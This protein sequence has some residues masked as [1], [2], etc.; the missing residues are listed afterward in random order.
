MRTMC[1][2]LCLLLCASGAP[3]LDVE[4][5]F[6]AAND[7][8]DAKQFDRAIG[9]YQSLIEHG[10]IN[11]YIFYNLGTAYF[12]TG[13]L[14]RA[15]LNY[16][17]AKRL[18]PRFGDLERNLRVAL[19]HCQDSTPNNQ[20][21]DLWAAVVEFRRRFTLNELLACWLLVYVALIGGLTARIYFSRS[22]LYRAL[23]PYLLWPGVSAWLLVNLAVGA[24]LYEQRIVREAVVI[25]ATAPIRTG[26][27]E[28]Q[29]YPRLFQLHAG[30]AVRV[31][32]SHTAS[33]TGK[34]YVKIVTP[35]GY[36]GWTDQDRIAL[37]DWR[38]EVKAENTTRRE[39]AVEP[40]IGNTQDQTEEVSQDGYYENQGSSTSDR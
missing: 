17:R 3:A 18:L 1:T 29:D 13:D 34:T 40:F 39:Q 14:G 20:A 35:V 11:G 12:R 26:P 4:A 36:E 5:T 25:A 15:I 10:V 31:I 21:T 6:Q 32:D 28:E 23:F 38:D 7:A 2:G 24:T 27:G 33:A 22:D 16:R 8:Y 9:L 37:I 30:A 19:E